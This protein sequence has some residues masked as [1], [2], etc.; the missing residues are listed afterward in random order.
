MD[1]GRRIKDLSEDL[2]L[3]EQPL[4]TWRRQARIDRGEEP[5]LT[6]RER[7]E[8]VA[9]RR[10]L[11]ELEAELT[12][13]RRATELLRQDTSCRVLGVSV[14]GYFDWHKRPMSARA[15]RDVWL[16]G[17]HSAGARRLSR[18]LRVPSRPRRVRARPRARRRS[19]TR[20]TP[21]AKGRTG[22]RRS[23]FFRPRQRSA[24]AWRGGERNR[25]VPE[26]V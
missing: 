20:R 26:H 4:Y 7:T 2:G 15:L 18:Y 19:T 10:R 16:S 13:H 22:L 8:L 12:V 9:M 21:H 23:R 1:A 5:G 6:T 3:S 25:D 24:R 11:R 14:S 17:G